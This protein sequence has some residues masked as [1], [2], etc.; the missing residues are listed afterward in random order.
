MQIP[1]AAVPPASPT[2][3]VTVRSESGADVTD[4]ATRTVC[5]PPSSET[6][7][8]GEE[9]ASVKLKVMVASPVWA[10]AGTA[11]AIPARLTASMIAR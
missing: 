1:A 6:S 4:A 8:M 7:E 10:P 9:A 5:A 2:V 11:A 3:T